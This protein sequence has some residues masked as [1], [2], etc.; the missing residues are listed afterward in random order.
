MTKCYQESQWREMYHNEII[1]LLVKCV[2]KI[3]NY[4]VLYKHINIL[5]I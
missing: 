4:V 3:D 2:V 5:N 1:C